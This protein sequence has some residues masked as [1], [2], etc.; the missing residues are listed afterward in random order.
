MVYYKLDY[1]IEKVLQENLSREQKILRQLA[2]ATVPKAEAKILWERIQ[3]HKWYVSERLKRDV[4]FR[5]AA[6]DYMENFYEPRSFS[7]SGRKGS[8]LLEKIFKPLGSNLRSYF[9]AKSKI[10]T[11]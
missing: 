1:T 8:S 3:D 10:L 2:G 5:V 6:V 4:G 7:T 9:V 11:Q